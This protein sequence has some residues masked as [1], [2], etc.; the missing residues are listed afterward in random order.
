MISVLR[1]WE[2]YVQ[3]LV[4]S[5][6]FVKV[7]NHIKGKSRLIQFKLPLAGL[8]LFDKIVD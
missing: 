3:P 7:K 8:E 5:C 4:F 6:S 2:G 1:R